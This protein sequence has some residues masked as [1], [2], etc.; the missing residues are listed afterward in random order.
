MKIKKFT[1]ND[2][3]F[4]YHTRTAAFKEKFIPEIGSNAA[5]IAGE[6]YQ[7]EDY[8]RL[9]NSMQ[10][11]IIHEH[12]KR[13]GF[14]TIKIVNC[15]T[16]E[17]P[18]I[19]ISLDSLGQGYGSFAMRYIE[20][21]LQQNQPQIKTIFLDTIIPKYNGGFYK[22]MGYRQS[23]SSF[24]TFGSLRI[25]AIRFEKSLSVDNW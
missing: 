23:G 17:I 9:A 8:I 3:E 2:A 24:C 15:F 18:L 19:Y 21:W 16:A 11:F 20:Q 1:A 7:P 10:I 5:A 6:A 13:E 12:D 25:P 4:C 14:F 22:K